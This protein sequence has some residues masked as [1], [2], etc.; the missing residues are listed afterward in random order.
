MVFANIRFLLIAF[1]TYAV[2]NLAAY[3]L[4]TLLFPSMLLTEIVASFVSGITFVALFISVSRHY[5]SPVSSRFWQEFAA[6]ALS[7]FF[8]YA[9]LALMFGESLISIMGLQ[10]APSTNSFLS[11][12]EYRILTLYTYSISAITDGL[13]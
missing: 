1:A 11:P 7:L 2:V 5:I 10:I 4:L 13:L 8:V 6:L 3:A 12:S 9:L